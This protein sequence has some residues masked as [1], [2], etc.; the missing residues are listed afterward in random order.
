ME[1]LYI[2]KFYIEKNKPT[3]NK[4]FSGLSSLI[5]SAFHFHLTVTVLEPLYYLSQPSTLTSVKW[6]E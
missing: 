2:F 3:K 6:V 5:S 1:Q 4:Q